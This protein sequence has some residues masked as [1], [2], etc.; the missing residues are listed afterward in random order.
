[1]ILR[2]VIIDNLISTRDINQRKLYGKLDLYSPPPSTHTQNFCFSYACMRE[3]VS[4]CVCVGI[5]RMTGR[6]QFR[7]TPP[8]S[9]PGIT[10]AFRFP[11]SSL[12]FTFNVDPEFLHHLPPPSSPFTLASTNHIH[13]NF[14]ISRKKKDFSFE[15][16]NAGG[17]PI[18]MCLF[19]S[20]SQPWCCDTFSFFWRVTKSFQT[21]TFLFWYIQY[22]AYCLLFE[23]SSKCFF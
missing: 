1:M 2:I 9:F 18:H 4:V 20:G 23:Y 15:T 16:S 17:A 10:S 6:T 11:R 21:L 22:S 8:P 7:M 14:K 19:N 13:E 5:V 12:F 3:G